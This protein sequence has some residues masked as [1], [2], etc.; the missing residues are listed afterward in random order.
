MSFDYD[1]L[2]IDWEDGTFLIVIGG[3]SYEY[4]IADEGHLLYGGLQNGVDYTEK[5]PEKEENEE[6]EEEW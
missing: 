5:F 2:V 1:Y 6:Q 4:N 3:N